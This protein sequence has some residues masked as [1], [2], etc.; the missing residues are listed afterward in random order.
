VPGVFLHALRDMPRNSI[1]N[2]LLHLRRSRICLFTFAERQ[3]PTRDIRHPRVT[4]TLYL[5]FHRKL[6]FSHVAE[7]SGSGRRRHLPPNERGHAPVS[8]LFKG[9]I[10]DWI[11][12]TALRDDSAGRLRKAVYTTHSFEKAKEEIIR[13]KR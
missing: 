7:S 2:S 11:K 6:D 4:D 10:T 12:Y 1:E 13:A 3:V 5:M 8:L 9:I